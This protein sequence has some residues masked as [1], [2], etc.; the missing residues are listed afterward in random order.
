MGEKRGQLKGLEEL[1]G[2]KGRRERGAAESAELRGGKKRIETTWSGDQRNKNGGSLERVRENKERRTRT[3]GE[4]MGIVSELDQERES[5]MKPKFR[6]HL[7]SFSGSSSFRPVRA[8]SF[9]WAA[10]E[11]SPRRS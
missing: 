8:I 7:G 10:E 9:H 3:S 5:R 6:D 2:L 4:L 11:V 1:K